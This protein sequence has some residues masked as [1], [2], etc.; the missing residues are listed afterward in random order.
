LADNTWLDEHVELYAINAL[1]NDEVE[2]LERELTRAPEAER[3]RYLREIGRTREALVQ[4]TAVDETPPPP[5][6]RESLLAALPSALPEVGSA[7]AKVI[8][9]AERRR[10]FSIA[11]SAVAAALILVIGGVMVGRVT[12]PEE[13]APVSALE[14]QT[15]A[16]LGAGDMQ[17]KKDTLSDGGSVTVATSRE[18]NQAVVIAEGLPPTPA[19]QTYQMWL[20]GEGHDP[21]SV[22]TMGAEPVRQAVPIADLTGS[23]RIAVTIEPDG[24]SPQPTGEVVTA[25][26]F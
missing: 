24:G 1:D 18:A 17:L 20:L 8:N 5:Q 3:S 11:V 7:P 2:R 23:D 13:K 26:Q 21:T 4:M 16:I 9:L 10:R 15:M 12:A 19:G 14:Q 6:L 22:G 25:V